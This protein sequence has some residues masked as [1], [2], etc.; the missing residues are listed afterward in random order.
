MQNTR[1]SGPNSLLLRDML[2]PASVERV[3]LIAEL[4]LPEDNS[5]EALTSSPG[6]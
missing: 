1:L 6:R 4:Y 5:R 3:D 2:D